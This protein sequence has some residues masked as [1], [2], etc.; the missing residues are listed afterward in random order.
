MPEVDVMAPVASA[1]GA[2]GLTRPSRLCTVTMGE[3]APTSGERAGVVKTTAKSHSPIAPAVMLAWL[4]GM[5][6]RDSTKVSALAVSL[7]NSAPVTWTGL[8]KVWVGV[9]ATVSRQKKLALE[10][11]APMVTW[12]SEVAQ[13]E[14]AKKPPPVEVELKVTVVLAGTW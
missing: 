6:G 2:D 14:S 5:L 7:N 9:P 11:P 1:A 3:Q 12:V 8:V 13:L 10:D 4:V